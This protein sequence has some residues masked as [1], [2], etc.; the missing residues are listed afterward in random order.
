MS[1][2]GQFPGRFFEQRPRDR[3][4]QGP[5]DSKSDPTDTER[6]RRHQYARLM[7][8]VFHNTYDNRSKGLCTSF[9]TFPTPSTRE[10]IRNLGLL[11]RDEGVGFSVGYNDTRFGKKALVR[12]LRRNAVLRQ[13]RLFPDSPAEWDC[14]QNP[15]HCQ[16]W[17]R[18]S[19]VLRS[20]DPYFVN[21]SRIPLDT[22]PSQRNFYFSN[23]QAH[24]R[25]GR[26]LLNP[27]RYVNRDQLFDIVPVQFG[28]PVTN[29][30]QKVEVRDISGEV[31]LCR[32]R[33]MPAGLAFRVGDPTTISCRDVEEHETRR[34]DPER[35]PTMPQAEIQYCTDRIYLNF[36]PLPE[37]KYT[38]EWVA[39]DGQPIEARDVVYTAS[40]PQPLCFID[41][42]FTAPEPTAGE[43]GIYPVRDLWSDD[44]E[45]RLVSYDLA[46]ERRS[47]FWWYYV[48]PRSPVEPTGIRSLP[49]HDQVEFLGP[50]D[51]RLANDTPALLFKSARPIP[52]QQQSS[53]VFQLLGFTRHEPVETTLVKRLP[54]A[55][56]E[57]VVLEP[58]EDAGARRSTSKIY[59]Y[60]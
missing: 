51:A 7:K 44:P 2:R 15:G 22:N 40:D 16:V 57:Q 20:T 35:E 1:P 12:F 58:Q 14:E 11:F 4:L 54:V 8:V 45:I 47:T 26:V 28:V 56:P 31:V 42:L 9:T 60:V 17:A 27:A 13:Q 10:L 18:L 46:F 33:C 39:V 55:S 24:R 36:A 34:E 38:I 43:P 5:G 32:P 6:A 59:V 53:Y 25:D 30:V 21:S 41:L 37:D 19:F 49:P 23:Q 52:L 48:V 3:F 29:Q 50:F